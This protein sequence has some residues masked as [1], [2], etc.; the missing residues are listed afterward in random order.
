MASDNTNALATAHSTSVMAGLDPAIRSDTSLR[1]MSGR[2]VGRDEWVAM[3]E[4]WYDRK[5]EGQAS[6]TVD[7]QGVVF[8]QP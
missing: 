4:R 6:S 2:V 7:A 5:L 8:A 3:S 1:Q